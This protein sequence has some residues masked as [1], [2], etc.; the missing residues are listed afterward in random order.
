MCTKSHC[1]FT[2]FHYFLNSSLFCQSIS[3]TSQSQV[4]AN[5]RMSKECL[6]TGNY[7]TNKSPSSD[8][9]QQMSSYFVL[10]HKAKILF[11]KGREINE[12]QRETFLEC[13]VCERNTCRFRS[14]FDLLASPI[15]CKDISDRFQ[16][17]TTSTLMSNHST[18]DVMFALRSTT[19]NHD[20]HQ[21]PTTNDRL[22]KS[23]N[24]IPL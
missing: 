12:E 3:D 19:G 16:G 7:D 24:Y 15:F 4:T 8:D 23:G 10:S 2:N 5:I 20:Q 22:Q 17:E 1:F 9:I 14:C 11:Y 13:Q 6:T 21:L 18:S